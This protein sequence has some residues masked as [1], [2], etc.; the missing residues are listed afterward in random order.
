[1]PLTKIWKWLNRASESLRTSNITF[2]MAGDSRMV[3]RET[4]LLFVAEKA[5]PPR[6]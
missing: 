5:V 4:E 3:L 6:L 2:G 1:M